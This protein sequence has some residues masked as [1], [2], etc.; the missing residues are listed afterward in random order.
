MESNEQTIDNEKHLMYFAYGSNLSPE[1]MKD[2]CPSSP[3]VGLAYLSGWTWLINERGYAN[4][5][6]HQTSA[7]SALSNYSPSHLPNPPVASHVD[8]FDPSLM[9]NDGI[10]VN[11]DE[12]N[13]GVK[14]NEK[15]SEM[16]AKAEGVY[17]V[18]YRLHPNDEL[19]LDMCEGVPWAYEKLLAD[20]TVFRTPTAKTTDDAE[21][22]DSLQNMAQTETVRALVY[23]DFK[24]I[25]PS[26]PKDEYIDRMNRGIDQAIEQWGLPEWYVEAVMRP[27]IPAVDREKAW[28]ESRRNK[29]PIS[30][31][32]NETI[33]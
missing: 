6:Q 7:A 9:R 2:R 15:K 25:S 24:R 17:G 32:K 8:V 14:A 21:T 22:A 4:V 13:T 11:G 1:Q 3:A 5:V 16:R 18:L 20:V 19:T 33:S 10:E 30:W 29:G 26:A 12:E 27:F 31:D 23:V 28:K